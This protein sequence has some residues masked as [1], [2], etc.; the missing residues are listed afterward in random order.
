MCVYIYVLSLS[1]SPKRESVFACIVVHLLGNLTA[2]PTWLTVSHL[3]KNYSP[4]TLWNSNWKSDEA[5]SSYISQTMSTAIQTRYQSSQLH[6]AAAVWLCVT[7]W[8]LNLY[9]DNYLKWEMQPS[10]GPVV[11]TNQPCFKG[12]RS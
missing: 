8:L 6:N 11:L 5:Q 4:Q 12:V 7:D 3:K 2:I 9:T 10:K 1:H